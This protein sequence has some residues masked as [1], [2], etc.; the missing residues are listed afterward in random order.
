MAIVNTLTPSTAADEMGNFQSY[1]G[2]SYTD[3]LALAEHMDDLSCDL[4]EPI[5]FDPV[6]WAC[7]FSCYA[8]PLEAARDLG[9]D[10]EDEHDDEHCQVLKKERSEIKTKLASLDPDRDKDEW[11]QLVED[12]G[13]LTFDIESCDCWCDKHEDEQNELALK[14]LKAS[15]LNTLEYSHSTII[16]GYDG[17]KII[18]QTQHLQTPTSPL[19]CSQA[20]RV[21][22]VEPQPNKEAQQ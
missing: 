8:N 21:A 7:G 12:L 18:V 9:F 10:P 6:A 15:S 4:G 5:D 22:A 13:G 2:W 3:R 16:R 20:A 14:W 11:S 17:H 1:E 19:I